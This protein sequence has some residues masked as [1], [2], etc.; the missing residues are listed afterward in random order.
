MRC[1]GRRPWMALINPW[2][3][4]AVIEGLPLRMDPSS[5]HRPQ[6]DRRCR[7]HSARAVSVACGAGFR[8][9]GRGAAR[10]SLARRRDQDPAAAARWRP[11]RAGVLDRGRGGGTDARP[12]SG[13]GLAAIV[14]GCPCQSLVLQHSG[15]KCH[16]NPI[17]MTSRLCSS[18]SARISTNFMIQAT[19][20]HPQL[21]NKHQ[22][23]HFGGYIPSLEAVPATDVLVTMRAARA[24]LELE[25]A[26]IAISPVA[27]SL[28]K[29]GT[30]TRPSVRL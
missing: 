13:S 20:V 21:E 15:L 25:T 14:S 18:P 27:S 1:S 9:G 19:P 17:C 5:H 8:S 6:P 28:T 12:S 4:A 3:L 11:G 2:H 23:Y 26:A 30:S 10:R 16:G 29:H 22:K 7:P 24:A